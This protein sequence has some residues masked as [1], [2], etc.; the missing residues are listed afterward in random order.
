MKGICEV[1]GVKKTSF[2]KQPGGGK[3]DIHSL[4]GKLPKPKS[5]W[6]PPGYKYMGPYNPLDKQLE[7]DLE[8]RRSLEVVCKTK[9]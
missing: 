4:I 3:L 7:Y 5:G 9:E 2:V 6:T 1:C 8:H